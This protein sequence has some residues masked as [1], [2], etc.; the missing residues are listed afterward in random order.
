TAASTTPSVPSHSSL[1]FNCSSAR[2][3]VLNPS[4]KSSIRRLQRILHSDGKRPAPCVM[5][6]CIQF[7]P[8]ICEIR[9]IMP[10]GGRYEI[11]LEG[12]HTL[13]A[14]RYSGTDLQRHRDQR[15]DSIQPI[16]PRRFWS[17]RL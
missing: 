6:S 7:E 8:Q 1:P 13:S 12:S 14:G 10:A 16:A 3:T 11:Y 2:L 4:V 17:N 15:K 9:G 5:P